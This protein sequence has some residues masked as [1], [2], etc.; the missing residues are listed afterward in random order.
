[1]RNDI[2][3]LQT[4]RFF[5]F[6]FVNQSTINNASGKEQP[7]PFPKKNKESTLSLI[8]NKKS[9]MFVYNVNNKVAPRDRKKHITTLSTH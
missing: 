7:V 8:H 1:M 2:F 5:I 6:R 9:L 4:S 3:S